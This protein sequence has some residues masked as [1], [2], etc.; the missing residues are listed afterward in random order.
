MK[1]FFKKI[2]ILHVVIAILLV[3]VAILYFEVI[4][5]K[6]DT[7]SLSYYTRDFDNRDRFY[8]D[9][10]D[11]DNFHHDRRDFYHHRDYMINNDIYDAVSR[12]IFNIRREFERLNREFERI[13]N[14]TQREFRRQ[15]VYYPQIKNN[16]ESF[17]FSLKLPKEI[18][19]E[20][21]KVDLQNNN[22][23]IKI[24]KNIKDENSSFST[25]FFESYT[26]PQT[27]ATMKDVKI[28]FNKNE[29]KVIVPILK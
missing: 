20:D 29:L 12:E 25:S 21:I 6:K 23:V 5:L 11:W 8:Q 9:Y 18:N 10:N 28:D 19:K 17:E 7:Y 24:D 13:N 2:N 4:S 3:A 22:L 27:K 15:F 26:L 14:R 16:D 1:E